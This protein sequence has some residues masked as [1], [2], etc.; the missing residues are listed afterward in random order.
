MQIGQD[1]VYEINRS[2][3][4]ERVCFNC[5]SKI[6]GLNNEMHHKMLPEDKANK[7]ANLKVVANAYN[8]LEGL[9][10]LVQLIALLEE[11]NKD[12]PEENADESVATD[13]NSKFNHVNGKPDINDVPMEDNQ[14]S[15]ETNVGR[16]DLNE[17][18]LDLNARDGDEDSEAR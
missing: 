4:L 17:S 3:K 16:Q 18:T 5:G 12:S 13:S 8:N 15:E 7:N 11:Q 1:L 2:P 10:G 14:A 6:L 9:A